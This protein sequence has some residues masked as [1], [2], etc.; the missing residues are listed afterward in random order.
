MGR[1]RRNGVL[2][3]MALALLVGLLASWLWA[4]RVSASAREEREDLDLF[5]EASSA[6]WAEVTR[7]FFEVP[8]SSALTVGSLLPQME[9]TDEKLALLA[10]VV[11]RSSQLDAAFVGYPNGDFSFVGRS[12]DSTP[13]GFRTRVITNND[14]VRRVDLTWTDGSLGVV[15]S[16]LDVVD[17][18]DPRTRPWYSP[19]VDDSV[20]N[21]TEPYVFS[22]SQQPGI[23]HSVRVTNDSGELEAVVGVDIRLMQVSR[24]LGELSPG[25]NGEALV[26]DN[27]GRVIATSPRPSDGVGGDGETLPLDASLELGD[28]I[29]ALRNDRT[30]DSVRGQSP[31]GKRTTIV[32]V[33]G[34]RDEWFL[35]VR[36]LDEDFIDDATASNAFEILAVGVAA[37]AVAGS[38]GYGA[39]RY[40]RG[41]KE[42]ADLDELTGIPSR[43]AIRRILQSG[44]ARSKTLAFV[45]IVDLDDFKTVNDTRGHAAGDAVLRSA[46]KIIEEF[47]E[48]SNAYAGRLGG[49]EFLLYSEAVEPGW[50]GLIDSLEASPEALSASIGVAVSMPSPHDAMAEIFG[51]ADSL[52]FEAK[53]AGGGTFCRAVHTQRSP[54]SAIG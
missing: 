41:L 1:Q 17:P 6:G 47:A 50:Q 26:V 19:I 21:W 39:L 48:S 40:L 38:V 18:F 54:F 23:T 2:V 32:R 9:T 53:K 37:A 10:E 44:L 24:F 8:E 46:A 51:A 27:F 25:D 42:E 3:V 12:D 4:G 16:E 20:R 14:G 28:L 13:G 45:A 30:A 31:D 15:R 52:L 22:S 43:R 33:G 49:D 36:A 5:L 7:Q 11:R 29:E 35:A 34:D